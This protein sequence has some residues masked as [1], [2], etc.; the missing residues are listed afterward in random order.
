MIKK[1]DQFLEG[2]LEVFMPQEQRSVGSLG[3][4]GISQ[5]RLCCLI[6]RDL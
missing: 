2:E 3:L 5:G 4:C 6:L 1:K